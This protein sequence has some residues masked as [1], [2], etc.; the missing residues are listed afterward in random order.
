LKARNVDHINILKID[1]EG[2]EDQA[3]VP[4]FKAA[5][6]SLWPGYL[7]LETCHANLWQD[8]LIQLLK[9][10]GYAVTFENARNRHYRRGT[11]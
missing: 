11:K 2:Y 9:D 7:M 6:E 8:D 4:F 1:I 10:N 3:L 5:P